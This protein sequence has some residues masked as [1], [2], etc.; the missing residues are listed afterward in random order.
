LVMPKTWIFQGKPEIWDVVAGV[1]QLEEFNWGVR[2]FAD[3]IDEGD[4]V[5]IWVSGRNGGIVALARVISK[6]EYHADC[7]AE[8]EL[9]P[10]GPPQKFQGKQLR[11]YLKIVRPLRIARAELVNHPILGDL[12]ILQM[13]RAT[14]FKVTPEQARRLEL[15]ANER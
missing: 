11:V 7:A 14:N 12:S 5:Y 8:L 10:D 1:N 3:E 6:P 2:Q 15:L 13:P 9:Y 4:S